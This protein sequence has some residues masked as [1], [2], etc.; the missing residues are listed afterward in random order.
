MSE[1]TKLLTSAQAAEILGVQ[2]ST[3]D[4]WRYQHKPGLKF[5]RIG[6]L[7]KYRLDD[8]TEYVNRQVEGD[9]AV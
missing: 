6:R 7:C 3:L 5:Y 1:L 4:G 9:E 8:I 2:K